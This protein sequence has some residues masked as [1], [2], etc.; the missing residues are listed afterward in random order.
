MKQNSI[1]YRHGTSA[2]KAQL[3]NLALI[4]YQSLSKDLTAENWT[5]L[6]NNLSKPKLM[7]ELLE[8]GHCFVC[9]SNN[10]LVGMAFI[11][12][13]GLKSELFLEEWSCIRMVG[14]N[15]E[16]RGNGIAKNLTSMCIAFA[17]QN[18]ERVIALHTGE[19]MADARHVYEKFGFTIYKEI[20][21]LFGKRY[22]IYTLDLS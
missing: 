9:E 13:S 18:N 19:H 3:M 7:D 17:K 6:K 21:P 1:L 20:E 10:E 4:A 14:V 5:L 16:Y 15:P 12:R 2:D 22:F 8:N 11:L